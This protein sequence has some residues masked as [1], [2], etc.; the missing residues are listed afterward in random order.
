[1]TYEQFNNY[2]LIIAGIN[3]SYN[4]ILTD[5][6]TLVKNEMEYSGQ[7][8][9]VSEVIPYFVFFK[10]CEFKESEV[11]ATSGEM[12]TTSELTMPSYMAQVR[13][14]NT[15]AAKLKVIC[16]EKGTTAHRYYT[17]KINLVC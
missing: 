10:F 3:Q 12:V 5:I 17:S 6:E 16:T 7:A 9:D 14:W 4:Q 15:G 1:M 13:A 11:S 8:A 2:P